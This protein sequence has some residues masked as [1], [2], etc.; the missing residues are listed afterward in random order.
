MSTASSVDRVGEALDAAH[1]TQGTLNAFTLI[2]DEQALT[3][4]DEIDRRQEG[5]EI[6]GPLAG[7]PVGLKDLIDHE[8]RITTAGSAFYRNHASASAPVVSRLEGAG[9]VIVGRTGLHEFAYGFSSENPHFGAVRNPWDAGTSPGGSSGGS[10]A[11]VAAGVTPVSI[12]TDT[13]GSIRV[14]AALCS[15]FGLKVTYDRV[16]LDGVFPLAQSVD[17]VGPLADSIDSLDL[18][19]RV[20]SGDT[21]AEPASSPLTLGIPQPWFD[22][23]PVDE[24]VAS[25]FGAAIDALRGL[26]HNV[27]PVEM[28][29]VVP[30]PQLSHAISREIYEVHRG[31]RESGLPYGADVATRLDDC[32][33]TT[34]EQAAAGSEWQLMIRSRFGEAM[35]TVDMLVTPTTPTMRKVIGEDLIGG[36]HYRV[37]LSWFT[38]LVNHALLPAIALP[39]AGTGLPAVS[40]QVI[41]PLGSETALIGLGRSLERAGL[42]GFTPAP[43]RLGIT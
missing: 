22:E 16:P 21:N 23:G 11:A 5:G 13:G 24:V 18:A 17:T 4:A 26:G 3:R 32:A 31:F 1:T 14:P 35:Q 27:V 9:A 15:C 8:G 6:V 43:M 12:G 7:M 40:L 34:E 25:G 37:V 28:P 38:A 41:G 2:D 39:V 10:A 42:V 29:G 30:A 33:A 36:R 19:Y 20:I